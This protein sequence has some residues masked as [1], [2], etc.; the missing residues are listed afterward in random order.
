VPPRT[1]PGRKAGRQYVEE[2][3]GYETP[4]WIWVL[5]KDSAGYG[6]L[7]T[8]HHAYRAHRVYWERVHGP[9]PEGF[10]LHHRCEQRS[11]VNP[12][13]QEPLSAAGHAQ[14]HGKLTEDQVREIRRRVAAGESMIAVAEAFG[15][16]RMQVWKIVTRRA[17]KWV[18]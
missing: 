15:V 14:T 2:D 18:E 5:R 1:K 7:Y 4:C 6:V 3:R 12:D 9:L 10:L 16:K 11:C 8:G 17:W 13:H